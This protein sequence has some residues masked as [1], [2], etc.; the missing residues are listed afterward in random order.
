MLVDES[1]KEDE[2]EG[3]AG[4][5]QVRLS[6]EFAKFLKSLNEFNVEKEKAA[7]EEGDDVDKSSSSSFE[8]EIDENERAKIIRAEIEKEKQLKRKRREDKDDELY[9]P[10]PEHVIE[11]QT[12]PSSGGRKNASVRKRVITPKIAKIF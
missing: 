8:E 9:N 6:P 3:D 12:P 2:A 4:G 1:E 7:G 10:S 11:S 5:D